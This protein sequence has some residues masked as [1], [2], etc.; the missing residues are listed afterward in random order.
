MSLVIAPVTITRDHFGSKFLHNDL[1]DGYPVSGR[2]SSP[3]GIYRTRYGTIHT[4][5]DI[6][7]AHLTEIRVPANGVVIYRHDYDA[8]EHALGNFVM[9]R[10]GNGWE[11]LYAHMDNTGVVVEKGDILYRG[12]LIGYVGVTGNTTGP[13]LH[14][15]VAVQSYGMYVNSPHLRDPERLIRATMPL[16]NESVPP[17]DDATRQELGIDIAFLKAGR[18]IP[19]RVEHVNGYERWLY[20][21]LSSRGRVTN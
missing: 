11:T 9:I 12:D 3:Q 1:W 6:A 2:I 20:S 17:V 19:V 16:A 7:A 13:H 5:I 8:K 4:G 21:F 14:F 10:H 18:L 15:M